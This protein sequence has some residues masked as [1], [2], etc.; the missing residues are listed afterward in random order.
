[1]VTGPSLGFNGRRNTVYLER[2]V[3]ALH[4]RGEV[5]IPD[6]LIAHL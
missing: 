5:V 2:A 3:K 4:E 6:D 1:M